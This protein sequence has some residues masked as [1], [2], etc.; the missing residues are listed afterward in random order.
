MRRRLRRAEARPAGLDRGTNTRSGLPAC[1]IAS[2]AFI[3]LLLA[4]CGEGN[5]QTDP[6]AEPSP[7][8]D[9]PTVQLEPLGGAPVEV[10]VEI[11]A[12]PESRARGLMF[13]E[14]LTPGT[15][16]LFIFPETRPLSFWMRN[17]PISLDIL[18]L[19]PSGTIINI[20]R[21]TTPY[22]EKSLPSERP[23]RFVLEVPGGYCAQVGVRAG[24]RVELG[25]LARTPA[26]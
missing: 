11:V 16:M 3:L 15:G 23:A 5:A 9:Y 10:R 26:T 4:G 17:T 25:A 14:S 2:V 13:R 20:H 18:Y 12:T 6:V 8:P 21:N 1:L 19:D 7:R 24:D 22:S